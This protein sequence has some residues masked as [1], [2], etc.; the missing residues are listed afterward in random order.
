MLGHMGAVD[1]VAFS[2]DGKLVATASDDPTARIWE[3]DSSQQLV[4]LLHKNGVSEVAF[5]PMGSTLLLPV[6]I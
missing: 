6:V 5:S 2:P 1:A 3:V 4:R